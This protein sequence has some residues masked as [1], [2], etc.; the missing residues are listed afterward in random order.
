MQ[1]TQIDQL[2]AQEQSRV[3]QF[4]ASIQGQNNQMRLV[5]DDIN[6]RNRA[7]SQNIKAGSLAQI[8]TDLGN[9]GLEK[10][11]KNLVEKYTGYNPDTLKKEEF[12]YGGYLLKRK[13]K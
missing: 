12:R 10:Y 7:A 8:G 9:I 1:D 5:T 13:K 3:D 4:N 11:T 2:N 6:A